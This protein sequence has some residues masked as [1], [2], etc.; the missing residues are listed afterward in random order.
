M[1]EEGNGG[2]VEEPRRDDAAA[3]PH[4][5][6][7]GEIEVILIVLRIAQ[8]RSLSVG[9]AM[10]FAGIGVLENVQAFRISRHQTVFDAVVNHL[11]KMAGAGGA[12]VEITFFGRSAYFVSSG[13]A[14]NVAAA[15]R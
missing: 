10:R 8:G 6:D 3:A 5:R 2:Q 13:R 11:D 9:F 12:A 4:F 1:F 15:G 7:V 14:V